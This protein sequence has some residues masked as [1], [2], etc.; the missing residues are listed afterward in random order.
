MPADEDK[1]HMVALE[2]KWYLSAAA[3]GISGYVSLLRRTIPAKRQLKIT[4]PAT[5]KANAPGHIFSASGT[6]APDDA[7][8]GP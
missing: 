7:A 1:P 4:P 8:G 2:P 6:L 3:G 5:R